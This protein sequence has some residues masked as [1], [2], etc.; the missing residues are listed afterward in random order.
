MKRFV[1][2]AMVAILLA[3][4]IGCASLTRKEKGLIIGGTAGTVIGG[5]IGKQ[6]GNTA[7][8]AIIGAAVGG[9]A[10]V[11]IGDYMDKQAAE[12]E[13]DLEG[14]KVERVGE[15]IKLTFESGILFDV[16]KAELRPAAKEN[17]EKLASI[18]AKY[19]DTNILIEGHTDSD[20][21]EEH[22][23]LLSERRA[24]SVSFYL[25]SRNVE[26]G[27][28][29][30]IGYGE[31]QPVADNA[32]SEGKQANRRVEVAVMANEKLKKAAEEQARK[33]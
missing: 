16:N 30:T 29:S 14:A 17:I 1:S 12:M 23:Q 33:G 9:A 20:G 22:N 31:T 13:N 26:S 28:M 8:G 18:F 27:R 2:Y 6:A 19:P 4:S 24:K 7:A 21:T 15:G 11:V 32:T 10:G 25:A 3:G 5:V